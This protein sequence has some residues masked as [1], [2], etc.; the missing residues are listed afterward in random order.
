MSRRS[1]G[2]LVCTGCYSLLPQSYDRGEA[3]RLVHRMKIHSNNDAVLAEKHTIC[4]RSD[5]CMTTDLP[6]TIF[7]V[8]VSPFT[9]SYPNE[10]PSSRRCFQ[11]GGADPETTNLVD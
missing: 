8:F 6:K 3:C 7:Y 4:H 9:F 11:L 2:G 5:T 10:R 1:S